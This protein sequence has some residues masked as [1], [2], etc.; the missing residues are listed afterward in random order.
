[1]RLYFVL[2]VFLLA[3]F[4]SAIIGDEQFLQNNESNEEYVLE[5]NQSMNGLLPKWIN[6]VTPSVISSIYNF[7]DSESEV[8]DIA[9]DQ[10]DNIYVLGSFRGNI[11][12]QNTSLTSNWPQ[13]W[14][15]FV[16]KFNSNLTLIWLNYTISDES[17]SPTSY[18]KPS[19]IV[20]NETGEV[21]ISGV[22]KS[23]EYGKVYFGL[24][25]H[26][27]DPYSG[28]DAAFFTAKI[29]RNG[30]W[31]WLNLFGEAAWDSRLGNL[32]L[33]DHDNL[34]STVLISDELFIRNLS[35][36]GDEIW[37]I[38]FTSFVQLGDIIITD[39]G[40]IYIGFGSYGGICDR[41]GPGTS[42]DGICYSASSPGVMKINN[43]GR[44]ARVF[45]IDYAPQYWYTS[46]TE[47]TISL[48]INS[49]DSITASMS[50][51]GPQIHIR[52]IGLGYTIQSEQIW[53]NGGW[54]SNGIDCQSGCT[55]LGNIEL[56]GTWNNIT[57]FEKD[58]TGITNTT[59]ISSLSSNSTTGMYFSGTSNNDYYYPKAVIARVS[60]DGAMVWQE[61]ITSIYQ[62]S[63]NE[64]LIT[65]S[66]DSRFVLFAGSYCAYYP[67]SWEDKYCSVNFGDIEVDLLN[68]G[69]HF[70][71]SKL[72][73][74]IDYDND[75]VLNL[76]DLCPMG[77]S[78]WTPNLTS[79]H[80]SDGCNDLGEDSDDD[81]D[82]IID[83]A[84]LCV[85]GEINWQSNSFSDN[86]GDGCRDISEDD[87]DD[88]DGVLDSND[89]CKNAFNSNQLDY[90][91][92]LDGDE[93]DSDDDN[94]G[95]LDNIEQNCNTSTLNPLSIPIDF[96]GDYVCDIMDIDDDNDGIED[97]YDS[98]KYGYTDW[99][100]GIGTVLDN[101][102]LYPR[103]NIDNDIDIDGCHDLLE[104]N[105]DDNDGIS[106]EDDFCTNRNWSGWSIYWISNNSTDYDS[107]GC[108]DN[109]EDDDN[110]NDGISNWADSCSRGYLNWTS[111]PINDY[112]TDGCEDEE[113][114]SDDDNDQVVDSYDSCP[115]GEKD[116]LSRSSN[117]FD[118]DGC[119]DNNE[120]SDDD[121]DG[122]IDINDDFPL[123]SL[124]WSDTDNDGI[125]DNEDLDDDNDL[126]NDINDFCPQGD[127]NWISGAAIG[128][129]IDQDGCQDNGEDLDDDNDGW[130]DIQED[131]C[132]SDSLNDKDTPKDND[133]D[134]ICDV[135]DQDD[136]NDLVT[137]DN[138]DFPFDSTR[139]SS[140]KDSFNLE[141]L[142]IILVLGILCL[143][144]PYRLKKSKI[145][146]QKTVKKIREKRIPPPPPRRDKT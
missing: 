110:D 56:N 84:D 28:Q 76:N 45:L 19:S 128:T 21:F 134:M 108:Q 98:C 67:E 4:S 78:D 30:S 46:L 138:D 57:M 133:M 16:A 39:N 5:N 109:V 14:N 40:D 59:H 3:S 116:W 130:S 106:D 24:N 1:M 71:I 113:E 18:A 144:I 94:D 55:L 48:V 11:S 25:Y 6:V 62:S 142:I 43:S 65:K 143:T 101:G 82:G 114:D 58:T 99:V 124:E 73:E 140:E 131:A 12:I 10:N 37:N 107:D 51:S 83:I 20:V 9:V 36:F 103:I 74:T 111:N 70:F 88:N 44:V 8:I 75:G 135:L 38:S 7:S 33:L 61:N 91:Q 64:G 137:D 126:I 81:N 100:Y 15:T 31:G 77:E 34:I 118:S 129:D 26:E 23:S 2:G 72:V 119:N 136:D 115:Q 112:D 132:G 50:I 102:K 95:W 54:E 97:I 121:N 122:T 68:T 93:C 87:D 27:D 127:I 41:G 63:R 89:N 105:D 53:T 13:N 49:D 86:D 17:S 123:N 92:D 79:D 32:E 96:D 146:D 117:D 141:I 85:R 22:V 52:T 42:D 35:T 47:T 104:D 66:V 145:I 120:D 80:D 139:W 69:K 125:G 90:D 29:D 60:N